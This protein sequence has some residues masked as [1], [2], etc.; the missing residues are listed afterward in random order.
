MKLYVSISPELKE[1]LSI[2]KIQYKD[3][4]IE[5]DELYKLVSARNAKSAEFVD[6]A[7]LL[8]NS[9]VLSRL[10][11]PGKTGSEL[12]QMRRKAEER[13][14]QRSIGKSLAKVNVSTDVKAASESIAFATH[15]ILAFISAF[16]LGYYAGE[17]VWGLEETGKYICGGAVS[18]STLILESVLFILRDNKQKMDRAE[19]KIVRVVSQNTEM[20]PLRENKID[21]QI[22][23]RG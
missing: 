4:K 20:M 18:F 21:S 7:D 12:E 22:R 5:I 2:E 14:Y 3:D 10:Q 16:L 9:V 23:K 1:F 19:K 8:A 11:E 6:M 15:F 17:Y 13:K